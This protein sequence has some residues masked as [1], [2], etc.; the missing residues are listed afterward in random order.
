MV[1]IK[2]L[3]FLLVFGCAYSADERSNVQQCMRDRMLNNENTIKSSMPSNN[4]QDNNMT[5]IMSFQDMEMINNTTFNR[6]ERSKMSVLNLSANRISMI[7]NGSFQ[8]FT[9][10]RVLSMENNS[11][12]KI[13]KTTF[14]DMRM[15]EEMIL[16]RNMI[17]LIERGAFDSMPN[18]KTFDI[19]MNCM[20]EMPGF[21]FFRNLKL[22]NIYLNQN[23]LT[24]MSEIFPNMQ[25]VENFNMSGNYFTNMSTIVNY[26]RVESLDMSNNPMSMIELNKMNGISNNISDNTEN[27]ENSSSDSDESTLNMNYVTGIKYTSNSATS[28]PTPSSR[29][30]EMDIMR[31][32][33]PNKP[34]RMNIVPGID[35]MENSRMRFNNS[36][37]KKS[38]DEE[39]NPSPNPTLNYLINTFKRSGM[40]EEKLLLM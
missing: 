7:E 6:F 32:F 1:S 9:N 16:S 10:V 25:Y 19:S 26:Y 21:I 22:R 24:A 33:S 3:A 11:L 23:Y 15:L 38:S 28:R 39:E 29:R 4:N 12:W 5:L 17:S 31:G 40:S 14:G 2:L 27:N 35:Y 20:F 18:L 37:I 36:F 34:D 30:S 13:N 8:G